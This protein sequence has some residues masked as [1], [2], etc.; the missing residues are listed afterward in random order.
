MLSAMQQRHFDTKAKYSF[1]ARTPVELSV[2]RKEQV[3]V[4]D[5]RFAHS[6]WI[7][8]AKQVGFN[9][10]QFGYLPADHVE[11]YNTEVII[12][13]HEDFL[14]NQQS[15]K[16]YFSQFG[17]IVHIFT[18]KD[19]WNNTPIVQIVYN[20][21]EEKKHLVIKYSLFHKKLKKH[22]DDCRFK[23]FSSLNNYLTWTTQ[24]HSTHQLNKQ[25]K[26]NEKIKENRKQQQRHTQ[27]II[28][29]SLGR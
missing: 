20:R 15:I 25:S 17:K 8:C 4:L 19:R 1:Q 12:T 10:Y 9:N 7:Y 18:W 13:F 21:I 11:C 28:D 22:I 5:T 14:P 29:D 27:D 2:N 3:Y 16:K 23:I 26:F 24:K 6:G